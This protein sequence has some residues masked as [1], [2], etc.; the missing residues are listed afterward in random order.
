ML[1]L[2][3]AIVWAGSALGAAVELWL[4]K[5]VVL[6]SN[7]S[8]RASTAPCESRCLGRLASFYPRKANIAHGLLAWCLFPAL[9][10]SDRLQ[11]QEIS[12][13]FY[14]LLPQQCP[15]STVRV[16]APKGG[17]SLRF[18]SFLSGP[19]TFPFCL[20]ESAAE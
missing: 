9:L 11:I 8:Q 6:T 7:S 19:Q 10:R 18:P 15:P 2:C 16:G 17:C 20:P 3:S 12:K 5:E 14:Q 13:D 4:Q 1:V